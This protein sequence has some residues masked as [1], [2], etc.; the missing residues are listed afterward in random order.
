MGFKGGVHFTDMFPSYSSLLFLFLLCASAL[1]KVTVELLIES[2]LRTALSILV[3]PYLTNGFSHPYQ[4]GES[5]FILGASGV[6]FKF[7]S[8]FR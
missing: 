2:N 1:E 6:F 5:T 4:L 7:Y 8:I 3:N